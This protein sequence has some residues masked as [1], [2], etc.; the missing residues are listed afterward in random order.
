MVSTYRISEAVKKRIEEYQ[1]K[2]GEL[3][4]FVSNFYLPRDEREKQVEKGYIYY[5]TYKTEQIETELATTFSQ[6]FDKTFLR[7]GIDMVRY[8]LETITKAEQDVIIAYCEENRFE[9]IR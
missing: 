3:R 7:K 5:P 6:T 8:G 9:K 4:A 1:P 2:P